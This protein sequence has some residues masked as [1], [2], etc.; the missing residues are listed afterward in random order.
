MMTIKQIF[1]IN[2]VN[3][4]KFAIY[5]GVH[6]RTV[7]QWLFNDRMPHYAWRLLKQFVD[8]NKKVV[9]NDG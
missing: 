2:D 6:L 4:Y 7:E 1:K 8:E 3:R 9:K 5:C